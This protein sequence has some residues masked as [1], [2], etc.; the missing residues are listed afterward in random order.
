MRPA[1][2]GLMIDPA[3]RILLLRLKFPDWTG[4]VTPGGGKEPGESDTDALRRELIE[5]TGVPEVFVGPPVWV[6]Q[7]F[8]KSSDWDG[9]HETVYLVPC[10]AFDIAPTMTAEELRDEGVVDHRW[11]TVAELEAATADPETEIQPE[12]LAEMAKQILDHGAPAEPFQLGTT[13]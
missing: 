1:V 2:R 9:Q 3:D 12:G 6:R 10:H 8:F 4:W 7:F 13:N 11:W 5:E